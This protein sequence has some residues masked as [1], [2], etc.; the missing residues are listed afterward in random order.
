M[1]IQLYLL[2]KDDIHRI[3]VVL[4]DINWLLKISRIQCRTQ[5]A[6]WLLRLASD[7]KNI[8]FGTHA[9]AAPVIPVGASNGGDVF[10]LVRAPSLKGRSGCR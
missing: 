5:P 1:N 2:T 10:L 3:L 9:L 7:F 6:N 8:G 4:W